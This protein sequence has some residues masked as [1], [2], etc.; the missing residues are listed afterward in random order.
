MMFSLDPQKNTTQPKVANAPREIK[1]R[2]T[3]PSDYKHRSPN[4]LVSH[5][6]M[7]L[8]AKNLNAIISHAEVNTVKNILQDHVF[9]KQAN[10][11]S[12]GNRDLA[13]AHSQAGLLTLVQNI[14]KSDSAKQELL[15]QIQLK[16]NNIVIATGSIHDIELKHSFLDFARKV[17]SFESAVSRLSIGGVSS[18]FFKF[19]G[20]T[21][22]AEAVARQL[23]DLLRVNSDVE[24]KKKTNMIFD[25]FF[26]KMNF[27]TNDFMVKY[28]PD[29]SILYIGGAVYFILQTLIS[30]FF[31]Y[32]DLDKE[33]STVTGH[34]FQFMV[35]VTLAIMFLYGLKREQRVQSEMRRSVY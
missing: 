2:S 31:V 10:S 35:Y 32:R 25:D 26:A 20:D 30:M 15:G 11:P 17:G 8:L 6:T 14:E 4:T 27:H 34:V 24:I 19:K 18:L 1:P 33:M 7:S 5:A 29:L 21:T 16:I 28:M 9:D 12:A 3:D 13:V 22:I 23:D